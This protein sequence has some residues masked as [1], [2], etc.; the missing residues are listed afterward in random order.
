MSAV[1]MYMFTGVK[2]K[3]MYMCIQFHCLLRLLLSCMLSSART[4]SMVPGY[5]LENVTTLRSLDDA[6]FIAS[7]AAGKD[8]VIVGTS[9]IGQFF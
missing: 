9:F 1:S 2:Q 7:Q 6:Q 4:L 5:D 3:H 8:V